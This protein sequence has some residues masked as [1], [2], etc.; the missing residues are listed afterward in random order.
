MLTFLFSIAVKPGSEAVVMSAL[1]AIEQAAHRDEGCLQFMWFRHVDSPSQFT[2]FEQWD[3]LEHLDAH[4]AGSPGPWNSVLPLLVGE[5]A[6]VQLASV[7]ALLQPPSEADVRQFVIS[8]FELLS[9]HAPV[10]E[11]LLRVAEKGLTMKFPEQTLCG[12]GD[13]QAWYANVGRRYAD[14][15]HTLQRLEIQETAVDHVKLRIEVLWQARD[16][17]N[18]TRIKAVATQSWA[19]QRSLTTGALVIQDY[20]VESLR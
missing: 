8:W 20:D 3:S 13:F 4:R 7:A 1:A 18:N 16:V 5:P 15:Q 10:E 6:S 2:L 17:A 9:R 14:Q 12:H 19:L 11:L